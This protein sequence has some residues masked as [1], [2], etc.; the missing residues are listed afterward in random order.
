MK[1]IVL[2]RDVAAPPSALFAALADVPNFAKHVSGVVGVE[3]LTAPPVRVG[4]RF[5]ET[6]VVFGKPHA[7]VL[8]VTELSPDR[9]FSLRCDSCGVRW[10]TR[11]TVEPAAS[12]ARLS[13]TMEGRCITVAARL[14]SPVAALMRGSMVKMIS[15][16]LDELKASVERSVSA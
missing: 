6:R 16:D 8:E 5:R 10:D 1:P 15:K 11:F 13:M 12:G 2:V 7:E 4:T 14:M 9:A 3:M